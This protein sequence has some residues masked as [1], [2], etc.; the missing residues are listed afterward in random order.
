MYNHDR[1][2]VNPHSFSD[3]GVIV[4]SIRPGDC[5]S[6]PIALGLTACK[7]AMTRL[8]DALRL[9]C[10]NPRRSTH[11][12]VTQQP[13]NCS[14]RIPTTPCDICCFAS[15][16]AATDLNRPART[17]STTVENNDRQGHEHKIPGGWVFPPD[18]SHEHRYTSIDGE[19][20]CERICVDTRT[21]LSIR[22]WSCFRSIQ[23]G[24]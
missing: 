4:H 3:P 21:A 19:P 24:E 16:F 23:L 17:A 7:A 14:A 13:G 5:R 15:D 12:V 11:A 18:L 1:R 20:H 6:I 9:S 10:E 2:D 22:S 8:R